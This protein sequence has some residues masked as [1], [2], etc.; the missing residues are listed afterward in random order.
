[1]QNT[2]FTRPGLPAQ[3]KR[4][5]IK[6][7]SRVL[8]DERGCPD[9]VRIQQLADEL[10]EMHRQ[11]FEIILVTSGAIAAGVQAMGWSKRPVSLPE[12]QMAAAVGQNVLMNIYAGGFRQHN[13][14]LGQILLTH[15]DLNHRER[16][17]NA[18][19]TML[20]M[21]RNRIIP[22]VNENDVVAVDEIRFGDNDVLASMVSTLV[23]GD[24]L[25]LL[26]TSDGFYRTENGLMKERIS[27]LK[28]VSEETLA[29]AQGKGSAWSSGGMAS[30]LK[31]AQHAAHSGTPVV[32]ANGL[33]SGIISQILQGIDTG[34]LILSDGNR[35]RLRARKKWIAFFHRP[36]G[37]VIVDDGAIDAIKQR[38]NSLLPVGIRDTE[39]S[40]AIGTLLNIKS[41]DGTTVARGLT[42][43]SRDD[44]QRIKGRRSADLPGLIGNYRSEEVIHRDNM[45]LME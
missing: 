44:I 36:G 37:S 30:K 32:I 22:V 25:I 1:M 19:N 35:N 38:G 16:H 24:L 4:I 6:A 43:Y 23:H 40:F 11:N 45:V 2:E 34:T 41:T 13:I 12:L 42:A 26:T 20:A 10:A 31:A 33:Q 3:L 8:V 28:N 15:D 5:V 9:H 17:L 29:M 18:R 39:G 14:T 7:G 27:T 21:L